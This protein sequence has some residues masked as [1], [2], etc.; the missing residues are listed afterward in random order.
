MI[1]SIFFIAIGSALGGVGR[2]GL[3]A[4]VNK[5]YTLTF[6]LGTFLVNLSGCFWIGVFYAIAS[7]GHGLSEHWKLFL[8]TGVCGGFTTFSAFSFESLQL[9]KSGQWFTVS[10]YILGSVVL[11]IAGVLAGISLIKLI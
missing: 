5:Y 4:L 1:R 6:P 10:L 2:F 3:Q 11:G 8:M 9:I 7:K